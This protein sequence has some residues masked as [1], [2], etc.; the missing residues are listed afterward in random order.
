[1]L[2][3]FVLFAFFSF[4]AIFLAAFKAAL[5][6]TSR[7][8]LGQSFDPCKDLSFHFSK[9]SDS[10]LSFT[11]ANQMFEFPFPLAK[12]ASSRSVAS[13]LPAA[14]KRLAVAWKPE[15]FPWHRCFHA[16]RRINSVTKELKT[17]LC[18]RS[19]QP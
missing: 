1:V 10:L 8:S 9:S 19:K 3:D 15:S 17:R 12:I 2:W 18:P 16:T 13:V 7:V 4:L 14:I 5:Y 11:G 6:M